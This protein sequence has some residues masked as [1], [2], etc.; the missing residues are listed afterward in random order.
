MARTATKKQRG[1]ARD[2]VDT[3]NATKAALKNYDTQDINTA[4]VIGSE[5]IRK[6]NV[7]AEIND[8]AHEAV[9][10]I[11]K[12][13]KGAKNEAVRLNANKDMLDRAGYKA[14]ERTMN[15]NVDLEATPIVEELA[16]KLNELLKGTDK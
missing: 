13:G 15:V 14:V 9:G 12:L 1:F 3:G 7:I 5:N 6:P 10:E 2:Y 8:Y 11:K 4:A 16:E